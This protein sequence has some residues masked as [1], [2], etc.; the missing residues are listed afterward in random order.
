M[1][2]HGFVLWRWDIAKFKVIQLQEI[3]D[4]GL[5]MVTAN[6][7]DI[8]LARMGERVYATQNWCPHLGGNLS[9]GTLAGTI[10]TCPRHHSQFDISDGKVVRWTSWP[11]FVLF[12][13]R[14]VKPPRPLKTYPVSVESGE[15][16]VDV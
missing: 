10:V 14:L 9:K 7:Q 1:N 3:P 5:T 11:P 6:G 2:I 12:F 16:S 4:G 15:V 8:L 13:A